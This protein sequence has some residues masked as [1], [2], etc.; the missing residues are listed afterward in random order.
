MA[1]ESDDDGWMETLRSRANDALRRVA[2]ALRRQMT[3]VDAKLEELAPSLATRE[4]LERFQSTMESLSRLVYGVG[5]SVDPD[6]QR[7]FEFMD[8]AER[9]YGRQL[10]LDGLERYN[11]LFRQSF[12]EVLLAARGAAVA[13]GPSGAEF[14]ESVETYRESATVDVL[15]FLAHLASREAD[16]TP[17]GRDPDAIASYLRR[18]GVPERFHL[19]ADRA[20]GR[21]SDSRDEAT[22][23]RRPMDSADDETFGDQVRALIRGSVGF[24][25]H[26]Q[27]VSIGFLFAAQ[28][29]LTR[30][31]LE[32]LPEIV[33]RSNLDDSDNVVDI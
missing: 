18:S 12:A 31:A 6:A 11:P 27:F 14:R 5:F 7:L 17:P 2:G 4:N 19:L 28:G 33:D 10:V 20:R 8:W 24:D 3:D 9:N 13:G 16:G 29:F 1:D 23:R 25:R 15:R 22:S 26:L 30:T 32:S 21:T